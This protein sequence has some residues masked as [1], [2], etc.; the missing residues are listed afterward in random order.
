M[1]ENFQ[2]KCEFRNKQTNEPMYQLHTVE[3]FVRN[4]GHDAFT[5]LTCYAAY[6]GSCL[7]TFWDSLSDPSSRSKQFSLLGLFDSRR[8][9]LY[10]VPQHQ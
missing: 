10:I 8:W 6:D 2:Y 4:K 5:L 7:S 3:S 9:G 1:T